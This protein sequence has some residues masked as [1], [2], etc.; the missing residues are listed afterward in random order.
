V[1]KHPI[2]VKL[3]LLLCLSLVVAIGYRVRGVYD[4]RAQRAACHRVNLERVNSLEPSPATINT[5]LQE[6]QLDQD[7]I[8]RIGDTD[9][10]TAIQRRNRVIDGVKIKLTKVN[11]DR[12]EGQRR[13]EQIQA[14]LSSCLA[15]VK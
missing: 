3:F 11:K 1:K 4:A 2:A 14:E 5:E 6:I 8:D 15:E 12:A 13:A 10:E 7:V 9:D